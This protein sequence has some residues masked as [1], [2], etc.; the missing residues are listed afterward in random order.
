MGQ[1]SKDFNSR[2]F[3]KVG[4]DFAGAWIPNQGAFDSRCGCCCDSVKFVQMAKADISTNKDNIYLRFFLPGI[5]PGVWFIDGGVPYPLMDTKAVNPCASRSEIRAT[6][7]PSSPKIPKPLMFFPVLRVFDS[8]QSFITCAYCA[9]GVEGFIPGVGITIYGCIE[10]S[11]R[12]FLGHGG[13]FSNV[14]KRYEVTRTLRIGGVTRRELERPY[15]DSIRSPMNLE[16]HNVEGRMPAE[17]R[18]FLRAMILK[19]NYDITI[20]DQQ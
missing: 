7:A 18:D 3:F 11:Q 20:P 12:F 5:K 1:G 6:D 15:L 19:P 9:D 14:F 13:R 17:F 16:I 2:R 8:T 10:W 4:A